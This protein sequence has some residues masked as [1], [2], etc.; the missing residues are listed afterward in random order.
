MSHPVRRALRWV[1]YAVALGALGASVAVALYDTPWSTLRNVSLW[2]FA[3]LVGIIG[4]SLVIN[5]FLFQ[6]ATRPFEQADRPISVM[7]WQAMMVATALVNYLPKAGL[8]GRT[9]LLKYRWGI[10]YSA[11]LFTLALISTVTVLI[12]IFVLALTMFRHA[13]DG[14]W[15]AACL[16]ALPV[17]A[18]LGVPMVTAGYRRFGGHLHQRTLGLW[19][20]AWLS[21]RFVD[22]LSYIGQ[23]Y[24][25]A[26]VMGIS[27]SFEKTT[28][29]AITAMFITMASPIPNGIGIREWVTG[30]LASYSLGGHSLHSFTPGLDIGVVER[31]AEAIAFVSMGIF[32]ILYLHRRGLTL[33]GHTDPDA[34][35]ESLESGYAL[36]SSY[37]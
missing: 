8:V 5:A 26:R 37:R 9:A 11:T 35:I 24:L 13:V 3:G 28:V 32:G 18:L 10:K 34:P 20:L 17:A 21:L 15:I 36:C 19:L 29:L 30:L 31:L 7:D 22:T 23:F 33:T 4:F 14:V 25:A 27:L 6:M 16:I 1:V 12:M 2:P